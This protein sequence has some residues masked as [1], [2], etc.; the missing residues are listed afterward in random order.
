M[1]IRIT[2]SKYSEYTKG[3]SKDMG[4][5][6]VGITKEGTVV[7]AVHNSDAIVIS[8]GDSIYVQKLNNLRKMELR[9]PIDGLT[10]VIRFSKE[11]LK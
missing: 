11:D 9:K 10:V 3:F 2:E 7:I 1:K 4:F 6:E 5:G 8:P